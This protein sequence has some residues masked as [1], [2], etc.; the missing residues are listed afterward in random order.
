LPRIRSLKIGFFTNEQLGQLSPWHRLLFAGLWLLADREGRLEDRPK[1]IRATLFPYDRDLDIDPM[2]AALSELGFVRRYTIHDN[3][4]LDIPSFTRHQLIGREEQGSEIPGPDGQLAAWEKPPNE[5][6]RQRIYIRDDFTCAYCGRRMAKSTRA[7]CVDHVIPYIQGGSHRD[8]NLVTA[9]KACNGKKWGRDPHQAQMPWPQGFGSRLTEQ[10]PPVNDSGEVLG[11]GLGNGNGK[12]EGVAADAA[13]AD[14]AP[15]LR[16]EDFTEL[17]NSTTKPPIPRC[18]DLTTK[19]RRQIRSRLTERPLTEWAEVFQRIQDSA[20]CRGE[21]DRGWRA[22]LDWVLGSP[23]VGVKVLEGKYDDCGKTSQPQAQFREHW[24]QEC[25]RVHGW[26][27]ETER[28]HR[29]RVAT[30]KAS[31]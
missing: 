12:R 24:S 14:G 13:G 10:Q 3:K 28:E 27:C 9:C 30:G 16:A 21:N 23:D 22:T 18:R 17:W 25:R 2:L 4:Y 6:V 11:L 26:A 29:N 19:R 7:R 8:D 15:R 31:A 5:T 1:R 20:F